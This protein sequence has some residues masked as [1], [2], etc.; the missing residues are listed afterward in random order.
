MPS[1][2]ELQL[3]LAGSSVRGAFET[4]PVSLLFTESPAI[5]SNLVIETG[6][7]LDNVISCLTSDHRIPLLTH[8]CSTI[9]A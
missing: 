6:K 1:L 2:L 3:I 8:A 7:L 9:I 4:P 5:K